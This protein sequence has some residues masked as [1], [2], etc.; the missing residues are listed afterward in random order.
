MCVC[1]CIINRVSCF[2]VLVCVC[3]FWPSSLLAAKSQVLSTRELLSRTHE[4][5]EWGLKGGHAALSPG[6]CHM[7]RGNR[8]CF[9]P[10]PTHT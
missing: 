3:V 1:V 8:V 2:F 5:R 9:L 7:A 6:R 4:L 10:T